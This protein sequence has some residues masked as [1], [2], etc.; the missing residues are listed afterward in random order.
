M[1]LLDTTTITLTQQ[2]DDDVRYAI[3]S[4]RWGSDEEEVSFADI[5]KPKFLLRRKKGY[6]KIKRCCAQALND[7]Y[8]YAWVD[9][10]C[11]DKSSS[12]ELQVKLCEN[13]LKED[14]DACVY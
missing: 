6:E 3:L 13:T 8:K 4:H 11:I 1:W 10:C 2:N 12:A 7:G 14:A 5:Q 9:T